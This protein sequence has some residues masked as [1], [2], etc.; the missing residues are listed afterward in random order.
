MA[1]KMDWVPCAFY[2]LRRTPAAVDTNGAF[3]ETILLQPQ[4]SLLGTAE[5]GVPDDNSFTR[6][7]RVVGGVQIDIISVS[8]PGPVYLLVHE[9]IRKGLLD[10]AGNAA[11]YAEAFDGSAADED[12]NEPFL[13]ERS[14]VM[15]AVAAVFNCDPTAAAWVTLIDSPAKRVL[16]RGECLT[17]SLWARAVGTAGSTVTFGYR[18]WLRT[19]AATL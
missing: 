9:R 3:T 16:E 5:V 7:E 12:A 1:L 18:T 17:H 14:Y 15:P 4:D 13:W 10:N 6:S 19:L 11:F 2:G 8:D